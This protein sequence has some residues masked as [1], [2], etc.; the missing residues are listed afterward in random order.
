MTSTQW[1]Q[2]PTDAGIDAISA[3]LRD[4]GLCR[5][6]TLFWCAGA[7]LYGWPDMARAQG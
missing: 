5:K 2:H 4:L 7:R 3:V 1:R 6:A